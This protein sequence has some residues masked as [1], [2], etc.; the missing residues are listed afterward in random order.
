MNRRGQVFE[1]G[2]VIVVFV[3][4]VMALISFMIYN[5]SMTNSLSNVYPAVLM[6]HGQKNSAF[7]A[8]ES[9]KL[10]VQEAYSETLKDLIQE[11]P[12]TQE[13]INY[14]V[15][16]K[17]CLLKND[18]INERFLSHTDDSMRGLFNSD[19]NLKIDNEKLSFVIPPLRLGTSFKNINV[20]YTSDISFDIN[21]LDYGID[22]NLE[23]IYNSILERWNDCKILKETQKI[24]DCM[25]G[26]KVRGWK[27]NIRNEY[28]FCELTSEREFYTGSF[29]PLILKFKLEK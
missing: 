11:C 4:C 1:Q 29:G 20:N 25:Y 24:K 8:K 2:L 14:V 13:N 7:Y 17:E 10:A 21:L 16:K 5:G 26:L 15:W 27:F 28:F 12:R 18:K 22:L 3:L 23:K 6:Y 9:G 19:F